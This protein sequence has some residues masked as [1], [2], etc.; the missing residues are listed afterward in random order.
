MSVT[1][2]TID[3]GIHD[4]LEAGITLVEFSQN[5]ENLTEALV[6]TP[7]L[8]VYWNSLSSVSEGSGTDRRTFGGNA[9]VAPIRTQRYTWAI[10]LYLDPRAMLDTIFVNMLPM[11][12]EING[13]LEAQNQ[14]PYFGV[15][16]IQSFTY[17]CQ[18]GNIEYAGTSYPVVQW[19][20]EIYVF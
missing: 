15:S 19:V 17:S 13:I 2:T 8:Q 9:S 10:D 7:C 5:L 4:T 12:D 16:A 11:V 20:L 3:N 14:K 18:R 6:N 1:L